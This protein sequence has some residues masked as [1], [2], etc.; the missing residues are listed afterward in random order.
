MLFHCANGKWGVSRLDVGGTVVGLL[1]NYP[2]QQGSATFA[3]GDLLIAFTDGISEAM[4]HSDEEWGEDRLI[5][6]VEQCGSLVAKDVLQRIFQDA[7]AF[8]AGAKQHDDMTLVV[9]HALPDHH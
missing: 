1:E 5:A 4:N 7:D 8:V 6:T 2:Y 3:A 9:L